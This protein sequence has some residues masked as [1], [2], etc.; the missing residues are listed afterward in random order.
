MNNLDLINKFRLEVNSNWFVLFKYRN[1]D[2]KNQW[3]C[4][5]S[6]MDWLNVAMEYIIDVHNGNRSTNQSMEMYAYISSIA[7]VWESVQQLHRVF[8]NNDNY[9]FK[10]EHVC[11][12]NRIFEEDDNNYFKSIRAAFGAH[13]VN[14]KTNDGK[15]FFASWPNLSYSGDY[16]IFLYTNKVDGE[17][18][19]MCIKIDELHNF[20]DIRYNYLNKLMDEIASQYQNFANLMRKTPIKQVDNECDQLSILKN[21]STKR[22]GLYNDLID[23]LIMIF[24]VQITNKQNEKMVSNFRNSL[25]PIISQI[26]NALQNVNNVNDIVCDKLNP[27]SENLSNGFDYYFSKLSDKISSSNSNYSTGW[28]QGLRKIFKDRF[29]LE[30]SSYPEFY[31]LIISYIY[32]LNQNEPA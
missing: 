14:I 19:I 26:Y 25:K 30:Y 29:I 7:I 31:V 12:S 8:F 2:D 21:E 5:C 11:F 27:V 13:S 4:I 18:K 22:L 28:E 6:A 20:L 3:N 23:E 1:V 17:D 24:D 9:P 32:K 16:S 10:N 15:K